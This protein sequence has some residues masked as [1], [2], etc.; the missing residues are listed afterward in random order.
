M[1]NQLRWKKNTLLTVKLESE[2]VLMNVLEMGHVFWNIPKWKEGPKIWNRE[3]IR[4]FVFENK[5]FLPAVETNISSKSITWPAQS[6]G[7]L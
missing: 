1:T 6:H 5:L 7:P 4:N 2:P 3:S